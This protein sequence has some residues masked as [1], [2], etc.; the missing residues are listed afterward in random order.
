M[1]DST[2][3]P[4]DR[5]Q[6]LVANTRAL[7]DDGLS[8]GRSV[9]V[10]VDEWLD[11]VGQ[12]RAYPPSRAAHDLGVRSQTLIKVLYRL[13][14]Q[15]ATT[16]PRATKPTTNTPAPARRSG[17]AKQSAPA[18][19]SDSKPAPKNRPQDEIPDENDDRYFVS[20]DGKYIC[21]YREPGDDHPD[22]SA[23]YRWDRESGTYH[24][25]TF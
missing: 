24:D 9:Q 17:P 16:E 14:K 21:R 10:Y 8:V 5:Y 25:F 4:H 11:L 22:P 3:A 1:T 2:D 13:R 19:Q 6:R 15:T 20:K 18:A 23:I 7:L 12:R